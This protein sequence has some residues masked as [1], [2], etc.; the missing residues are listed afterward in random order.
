MTRA[1]QLL[2]EHFDDEVREKLRVSDEH[3]RLYL[4]R[5]ERILMQLTALS[6][7]TMQTF[8]QIHLSSSNPVHLEEIS[9]W[10]V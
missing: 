1:R 9:A 2:F 7:A 4:N 6:C 5:Y 10:P 8:S 3:S